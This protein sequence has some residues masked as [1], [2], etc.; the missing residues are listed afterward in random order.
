M[1]DGVI[2]E[3]LV[4]IVLLFGGTWIN[5]AT[6]SAVSHSHTRRRSSDYLRADS[7]DSLESGY[8]S[9]TP[10]DDLLSPRYRL[11]EILEGWHKRYIGAFGLSFP[12]TTPTTV[13]FQDRLLSRLLRKLPFLVEC[14]YW[15]LVYWVCPFDTLIR[16]GILCVV[17]SRPLTQIPYRH[18]SSDAHLP[19]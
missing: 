4:V 8:S 17:S 13:V 2:L 10:K 7:P 14:W 18:I 16:Y 19:P 1:G 5:R 9:P 3:P 6:A 15:A 12:V 11:P